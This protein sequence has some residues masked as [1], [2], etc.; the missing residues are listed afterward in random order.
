[1]ESYIKFVVSCPFKLFLSCSYGG[2]HFLSLVW[3]EWP[4]CLKRREVY[5]AYC[6]FHCPWNLVDRQ[7]GICQFKVYSVHFWHVFCAYFSLK[8]YLLLAQFH[9]L[10]MTVMGRT[11]SN[12][13]TCFNRNGVIFTKDIFGC[14]YCNQTLDTSTGYSIRIGMYFSIIFY[15]V[16]DSMIWIFICAINLVRSELAA[17]TT[18]WAA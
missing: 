14:I 15:Y 12:I 9:I 2:Q 18:A 1:M 4:L 7:R 6:S 5:R 10:G 11:I 8:V 17:Y 3:C 13:S 16:I